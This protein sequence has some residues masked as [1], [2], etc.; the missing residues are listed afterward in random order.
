MH[1]LED[2]RAP[3][4]LLREH[5]AGELWQFEKCWQRFKKEVFISNQVHSF[6]NALRWLNKYADI[7]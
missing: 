5:F 6:E 7:Q 4:S 1:P 3:K 2:F